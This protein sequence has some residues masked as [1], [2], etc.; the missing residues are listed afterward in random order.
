MILITRNNLLQAR[1]YDS[2]RIIYFTKETTTGESAPS[3]ICA[4]AAVV[5]VQFM[6]VLSD[7]LVKQSWVSLL[8]K[9]KRQENKHKTRQKT[10]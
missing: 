5:L 7:F 3:Q 8:A 6:S 4:S 9:T 10:E 1:T 2:N